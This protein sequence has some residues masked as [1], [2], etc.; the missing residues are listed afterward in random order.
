MAVGVCSASTSGLAT[1]PGLA[2]ATRKAA[3]AAVCG[4]ATTASGSASIAANAA[5]AAATQSIPTS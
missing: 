4:I 2:E 1:G 5:M 3:G